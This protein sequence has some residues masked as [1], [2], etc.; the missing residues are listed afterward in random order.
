MEKLLATTEKYI[1]FAVVFLFPFLV[2]STSPNPFVVPKLTLLSFGLG[3]V[4]LIRAVRTISAGKLDFSIGS[5]DFPVLVLATAYILSTIFRTPNKMEAILLPGVTT[6]FVGGALLYYLINQFK[7][8]E[9]NV[10]SSLLYYSATVYSTLTLL[11]FS[12]LFAKIPQL[13][14]YMQAQGFSPEGGY[15]PTLLFLGAV[16]PIGLGMLIS[17]KDMAKR[18]LLGVSTFLIVLT[19]AVSIYQILP[20]R[21]FA[22]RFPS[23]NTSWSIAIDS[24]KDSPLLGVGPGNYLTAFNRYRPIAYNSTE[25]W[26]VRFTTARSAYLTTFTEAGVL[27]IAGFILLALSVYKIVKKDVKEKRAV[28]WGFSASSALISLSLL[29]VALMLLPATGLVIV[30]LFILLAL[31][32]GSRHTSLNLTTQG[33]PDVHGL[34]TQ[35]VASRF[36]ALLITIPVIILVG[37]FFVRGYGIVV[38]EY[39]FQKAL[40]ALVKNDATATYDTM[41]E[42]IA[43]NPTVDRYH[44][45]FSRVNLALANAIARN[46]SKP[47]ADG[48]PTTVSEQDRA[49]ITV[50]IQQA[51]NEAKSTVALNPLRA[52]N[53]EI[54]AQTYRSIMGL[55][56]GAD[57]FAL[58]SYRQAVALDPINPNM[59]IAL[60]GVYFAKGDFDNAVNV[61]QLAASAKPDLANAHYN[62]AIALDRKGSVDQAISEMTLV[63]SLIT[64][65]TSQDYQVANKAL[66]DM[67]AKKK[68]ATPQSGEELTSPTAE[69]GADLEPPVELPEGSEPPAAVITPTPT[70]NDDGSDTTT[71]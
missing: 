52:G 23:F 61:F 22:P 40:S 20:G 45:T 43:A 57:D 44:A 63:L 51:I 49:N 17:E 65:K 13:P 38:A 29:I 35:A 25:L 9:K 53:W 66:E 5:F 36:P 37:I 19:F 10:L 62:Y 67:Q 12:G 24:L 34:S 59:R 50:L 32:S 41:R 64:D 21:A 47:D 58:Q 1:L 31:N 54:L 6:Y 15:I 39:K 33:S 69:Q 30:T 71:L 42:A 56:Q 7:E 46:A 28:N 14:A 2:M 3:L 70:P 68:A 26:A 60:G 16:L 8:S 11:A 4:I 48:N 55:A 27:G 18:A